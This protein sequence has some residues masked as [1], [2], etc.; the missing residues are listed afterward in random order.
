MYMSVL[1]ASVSAFCRHSCTSYRTV[2]ALGS[3][4]QRLVDIAL[5][6]RNLGCWPKTLNTFS[7]HNFFALAISCHHLPKTKN[8]L[9][10]AI[11][12]HLLAF[13]VVSLLHCFC[14]FF[15][16]VSSRRAGFSC[17]GRPSGEAPDPEPLLQSGHEERLRTD[18]RT[19]RRERE[20]E[21][22]L[23]PDRSQKNRQEGQSGVEWS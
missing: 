5:F 10:Y 8:M 18:R 14:V 16:T 4:Q 13:F 17:G 19:D 22:F 11:L 1:G 20:R 23:D 2:M 12:N 6:D 15:S 3:K 21:V 9:Y 7:I